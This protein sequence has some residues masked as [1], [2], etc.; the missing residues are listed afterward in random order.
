MEDVGRV[1][2]GIAPA[3]M[4]DV[5]GIYSRTGIVLGSRPGVVGE[6]RDALA[7]SLFSVDLQRVVAGIEVCGIEADVAEVGVDA[8]RLA[9][10]VGIQFAAVDG[11]A[12]K[13]IAMVTSIAKAEKPIGSE[14][15]FDADVPCG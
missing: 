9:G 11:V 2:E 4:V 5:E 1:R 13:M 7:E 3:E 14:L 8:M 6:Q 12:R 15:M 10:N